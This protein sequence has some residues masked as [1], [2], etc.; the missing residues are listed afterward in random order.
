MVECDNHCENLI[1]AGQGVE[2]NGYLYCSR[3]CADEHQVLRE[4]KVPRKHQK[5]DKS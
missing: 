1:G 3:K 2:V 4:H 5:E